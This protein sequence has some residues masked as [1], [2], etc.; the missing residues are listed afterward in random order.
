M[1]FQGDM[2]NYDRFLC[3]SDFNP[4][5]FRKSTTPDGES[6]VVAMDFRAVCFMPLPFI[7]VA[8]KK[9]RDRFRRSL[10][11]KL[12]EINY[13]Q[14]RS[15]DVQALLTASGKLVPYGTRPVGKHNSSLLSSP[16]G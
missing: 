4:G 16:S 12:E 6:A 3:L 7:E 5:N 9:D 8:L 13:P 2:S 15:E 11:E 10:I 14:G 1:D